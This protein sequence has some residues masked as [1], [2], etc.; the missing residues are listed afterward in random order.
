MSAVN[1]GNQ[2][3]T[4]DYKHPAKSADFNTL[5]RDGIQ[6]GIYEGGALTKLD[7]N[8]VQISPFTAYV[9]VSTDKLVRV[10]T[11]STVDVAVS[12][13]SNLV[14]ISYNWVEAIDNWLD[15][16]TRLTTDP[17]VTNEVVLGH[18]VFSGT[19]LNTISYDYKTWG[20]SR[21]IL[22]SDTIQEV[23][24]DANKVWLRDESDDK[25]IKALKLIMSAKDSDLPSY[26]NLVVKNT[27]ASPN[28]QIDI[29]FDNLQIGRIHKTNGSYLAFNVETAENWDTGTVAEPT[30]GF[31]YVWI[32]AKID[33]TVNPFYSLSATSPTLPSGYVYTRLISA[34]KNTSGNFEYLHQRNK[35]VCKKNT[36]FAFQATPSVGLWTAV[37]LSNIVPTNIVSRIYG[38]FTKTGSQSYVAL[39][40]EYIAHTVGNAVGY[41]QLVNNATTQDQG[42][43]FSLLL[44]SNNIYYFT[45]SA[46]AGIDIIVSQ[47]E[48]NI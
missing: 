34:P 8:T 37:D 7:D 39:A 3:I 35:Y 6:P 33:G 45:D 27:V 19:T 48:L 36:P 40:S 15:F 18:A 29:T 47:Y 2:Y 32:M 4:F 1:Q 41:Q 14:Y 25:Y 38:T 12:N 43:N 24:E 22:E 20:N 44:L 42:G 26:K 17:V 16:N 31:V 28:N 9:Q 21:P 23:L 10:V 46:T 30:N 11:R 13:T 5:L